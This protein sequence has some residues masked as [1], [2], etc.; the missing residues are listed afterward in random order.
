MILC[1]CVYLLNGWR[2]KLRSTGTPLRLHPVKSLTSGL[3]RIRWGQP[4]NRLHPD[5]IMPRET[6]G[7]GQ[8]RTDRTG[9]RRLTMTL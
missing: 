8:D 5:S 1:S 2:A 7:K 3:Y 9:L 4:W 6:S